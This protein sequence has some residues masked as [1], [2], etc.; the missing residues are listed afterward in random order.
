[1]LISILSCEIIDINTSMDSKTKK[2]NKNRS[3]LKDVY[4]GFSVN[5]PGELQDL[6]MS[7]DQK[8]M[9][10]KKWDFQYHRQKR[11]TMDTKYS[12]DVVSP[13]Y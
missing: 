8:L 4:I 13:C 7:E 12:L 5:D 9:K 10:A 3:V 6:Y 2:F 11:E 1:M